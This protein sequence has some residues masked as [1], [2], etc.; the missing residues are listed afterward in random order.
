MSTKRAGL[1]SLPFLFQRS[2]NLSSNQHSRLARS[3]C[4]QFIKKLI[5]VSKVDL[6]LSI[7]ALQ[8]AAPVSLIGPAILNDQSRQPIA[9][10]LFLLGG[11]ARDAS[12]HK[13]YDA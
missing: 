10:G 12:K 5:G 13:H 9:A 2:C 7:Q 8:Q 1:S 6:C 11:K 3:A 4:C